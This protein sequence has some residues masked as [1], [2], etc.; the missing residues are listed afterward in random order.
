VE[1]Y[2]S[3]LN[4]KVKGI[5]VCREW[6]QDLKYSPDTKH[7]AVSSHDNK[8]Y[9]FDR[10]TYMRTAIMKGHSSYITHI[11]FSQNSKYLQSNSGDYELM[12]WDVRNGKQITSASSLR[13]KEWET[14]TCTIGWPVQGIWPPEADGTDINSVDR[15]PDQQL[16]A[17]ADDFGKVKLFRYPAPQP[18]GSAFRVSNGHSSHV[19]NVRFLQDGQTVISTGGNDRC[20]FHWDVV[21]AKVNKHNTRNKHTTKTGR[22]GQQNEH[23]PKAPQAKSNRRPKKPSSSRRRRR[24]R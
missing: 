17:T 9:I 11:D 18:K 4:E 13:D 19:T 12:F 7:L 22:K 10:K 3:D 8:I 5:S 6:I 21:S 14:W 16:L 2:D 24:R 1:I 23:P 20:I 15:S